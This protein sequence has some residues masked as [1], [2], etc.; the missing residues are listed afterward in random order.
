M[1]IQVRTQVLLWLI[2]EYGLLAALA[3][4]REQHWNITEKS[5]DVEIQSSPLRQ[6]PDLGLG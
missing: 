5:M 2:G 3:K 1:I 6:T 4:W